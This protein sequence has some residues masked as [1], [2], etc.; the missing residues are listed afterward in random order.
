MFGFA[1]E[2]GAAD[3]PLNSKGIDGMQAA[4]FKSSLR[5]IPSKPRELMLDSLA[6]CLQGGPVISTIIPGV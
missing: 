3:A 4:A 2:D 5:V 6:P 1:P